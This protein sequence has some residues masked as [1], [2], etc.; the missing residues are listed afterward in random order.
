MVRRANKRTAAL[1]FYFPLRTWSANTHCATH[2]CVPVAP[3]RKKR[4]LL[5]PSTSALLAL[6]ASRPTAASPE[7]EVP[8]RIHVHLTGG[9]YRA[10]T[11]WSATEQSEAMVTGVVLRVV[12]STVDDA[13]VALC[14]LLLSAGRVGCVALAAPALAAAMRD[15]VVV[16][17]GV[18][19][20]RHPVLCLPGAAALTVDDLTAGAMFGKSSLAQGNA[21]RALRAEFIGHFVKATRPPPRAIKPR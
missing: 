9:E 18:G 12:A 15:S 21:V 14:A 5:G 4:R 3:F 6:H 1:R 19:T 20:G 11:A 8:N 10:P 7:V 16:E 2:T 17:G 13:E